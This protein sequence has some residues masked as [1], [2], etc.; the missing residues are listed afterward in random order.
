MQDFQDRVAVVTGA[1]H[2]VGRALALECAKQGMDVVLAD[3]ELEPAEQ[4]AEEVRAL[5]RKAIAVECDV[6]ERAQVE[7]LADRAYAEFG[8]VHL[9]FNNAGV[10]MHR[11]IAESQQNEW[12]WVFAVNFWG[13]L[14]GVQAFLP[15]MQ[16]Q[17]GEAHIVNTASMSGL[18]HRRNQRGIYQAV[19]AALVAMTNALR[20]ELQEEGSN[21]SVSCF[22]PGG[23]LTDI[24]DA[25][26]HRQER[27][28]G[29]I[30][31]GAHPVARQPNPVYPE[32]I[33][34]RVLEAVRE[35]RRYIFSHPHT[36]KDLRSH[37]DEILADFEASQVIAERVG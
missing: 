22:C 30:V 12:D 20:S 11:K 31:L 27:F 29:P 35:N 28:G 3:L 16:A 21:V 37:Y 18:I 15:R 1:A 17:D 8:A 24:E 9:L 13:P 32:A 36:V 6:S 33:A 14:H 5:G 25:G 7:A 26:R 23:M 2:G 19:K 4:V 10:S 34:P